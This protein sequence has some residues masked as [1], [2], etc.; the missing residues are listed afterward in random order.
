[1]NAQRL[2]GSSNKFLFMSGKWL[3]ALLLWVPIIFASGSRCN[4]LCHLKNR[5]CHPETLNVFR[6]LTVDGVSC[7]LSSSKEEANDFAQPVILHNPYIVTPFYSVLG[8]WP[9][10]VLIYA[11]AL[12]R[13]WTLRRPSGASNNMNNPLAVPGR[14]IE[15][16]TSITIIL[17]GS[18]TRR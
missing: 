4:G 8:H 5:S 16:E 2:S 1:M 9:P 18:E 14:W 7:A 6:T 15:N 12:N 11:W 3:Y 17:R 10:T 13:Y